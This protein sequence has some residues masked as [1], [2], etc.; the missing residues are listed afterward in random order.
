MVERL[1]D[2]STPAIITVTGTGDTIA[3]DGVVTLREAIT[4]FCWNSATTL[5]NGD[6]H[7][8]FDLFGGNRRLLLDRARV[9]ARVREIAVNVT[10]ASGA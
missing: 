7:A 4:S 8:G 1:E 10:R 6:S 9:R 2:R 3:V 5:I